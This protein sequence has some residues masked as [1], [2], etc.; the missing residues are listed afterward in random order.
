MSTKNKRKMFDFTKTADQQQSTKVPPNYDFLASLFGKKADEAGAAGGVAGRDAPAVEGEV[1]PVESQTIPVPAQTAQQALASVINPQLAVKGGNPETQAAGMV[2]PG[3]DSTPP[4]IGDATGAAEPQILYNKDP[5]ATAAALSNNPTPVS[6]TPMKEASG[7]ID[8]ETLTGYKIA[9]AIVG[10]LQQHEF[11]KRYVESRLLLK[12]AG[13]LKNISFNDEN[14]FAK[15]AAQMFPEQVESCLDKLA[16]ANQGT[17]ITK[18]DIV[19]AAEELLWEQKVAE[20]SAAQGE[21]D[22]AEVLEALQDEDE[23]EDG[24]L[25]ALENALAVHESGVNPEV[26]AAVEVLKKHNAI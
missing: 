22:A 12:Q 2:S 18:K 15:T 4:M 3:G 9:D 6:G 5:A 11:E 21:A 8:D 10:R 26:A 19:D 17:R 7:R 14:E 23:D 16:N 1:I 25:E 24:D 13:Y 20:E